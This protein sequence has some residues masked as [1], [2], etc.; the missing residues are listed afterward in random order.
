MLRQ[1][2]SFIFLLAACSSALTVEKKMQQPPSWGWYPG[3]LAKPCGNFSVWWLHVPKCG[4][5]FW[6]TLRYCK[7]D[8]SHT[9]KMALH[10]ALPTDLPR[11]EEEDVVSFFRR[12]DQRLASMYAY[13][14]SDPDMAANRL[15]L[16][17]CHTKARFQLADKLKRGLNAT[18][19]MELGTSFN[20]CQTNMV[21]GRECLDGTPQNEKHDAQMAIKR[22]KKFRFVGLV[23]EW[24]LSICLF[25]YKFTGKR[26]IAPIQLTDNRPTFG[27][28]QNKI[29][30]NTVGQPR[31]IADEALYSAVVIRFH[32]EL[33]EHG[34]NDSA[35]P[36]SSD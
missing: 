12:P 9:A 20:G 25:N 17:G 28:M 24:K 14:A 1:M 36:L 2:L 15:G 4:S 3:M 34:I 30:Y 16:W 33:E 32:A 21:L 19:D 29:D 5:S 23:E 7:N 6:E 11:N 31:D 26:F 22:M 27:T 18:N 35:C 8:P 13:A 10:Q